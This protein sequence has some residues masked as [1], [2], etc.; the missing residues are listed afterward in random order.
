[1]VPP[2]KWQSTFPR[3]ILYN[4]CKNTSCVNK[5]SNCLIELFPKIIHPMTIKP[6]NLRILN[7]IEIRQYDIYTNF[8]DKIM[9][10]KNNSVIIISFIKNY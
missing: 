1:M 2:G 8:Y 5:S 9:E 7:I 3:D 4:G 6:V 10:Q